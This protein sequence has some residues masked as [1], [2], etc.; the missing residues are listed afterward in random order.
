MSIRRRARGNGR[1]AAFCTAVVAAAGSSSRMGGEDKLLAPLN[2]RPVLAHTLLALEHC[3][4]IREI[5]VVTRE[6]S[7]LEAGRICREFGVSKATKIIL[8]GASR[9][10]SVLNGVLEASEKAD[11]IAVQ[12]GARP[13]TTPEL[14]SA[15]VQKAARTNA[16]APAVPV[17]DTIKEA[18]E[19]LVVR[20]PD[21]NTLFAVQTPQVFE[22]SL[23]KGALQR[24]IEDGVAPTD[25]C[26]AVER[27]G[28][29][30]FLVEGD[31]RN[32]K[33]T[34]PLDLVIA[35]TLLQGEETV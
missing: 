34:T 23:L 12:D 16:A 19:G 4:E 25:D 31:E 20:T 27:I 28:M 21:R 32:L 5:I 33:I 8:G 24:A 10:E 22:A 1:K 2:G 29:S 26:G 13:L 14:I 9:T 11:L 35:G 18:R 3:P 6:E 30:V 7:L 17:K 15:V